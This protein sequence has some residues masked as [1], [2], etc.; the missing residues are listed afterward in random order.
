MRHG[1]DDSFLLR[2]P[3]FF[4]YRSEANP[5]EPELPEGGIESAHPHWSRFN[6]QIYYLDIYMQAEPRANLDR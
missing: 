3:R 5:D 1:R 4:G 6:V 2:S